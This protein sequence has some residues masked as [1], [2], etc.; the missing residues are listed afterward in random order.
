LAKIGVG[1][2]GVLVSMMVMIL[3]GI[4]VVQALVSS[5]T[6]AGWSAQ[7]NTTWSTLQSNIWVAFTLLVIIP[8]IL[9]AVAIL[10]Y[11][12]FGGG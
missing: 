9:G 7:A 2:I 6:Q 10:G 3:I 5:Q 8:I 1:I 11:L 4:V 12:R